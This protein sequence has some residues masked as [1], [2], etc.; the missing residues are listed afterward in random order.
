MKP[1]LCVVFATVVLVV[2]AP[3]KGCELDPFLFQLHGE[4]V[5]QAKERSDSIRSDF[6]IVG[7]FERETTDWEKA[8]S[9]Y[10]GRVISADGGSYAPGHRVLPSARIQPLHALKG[11]APKSQQVLT[12]EAQSGMCSDV[13]DGQASW[14]K[15]G[16]L[17]VVFTGLPRDD[18]RPRGIDSFLA[19]EIRTVDLLDKLRELGK[20]LED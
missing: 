15:P 3:A 9:V 17:V 11:E 14:A 19:M 16:E 5:A 13:G 18:Y 10:L 4:T 20:N 8:S 7:H 6:K 12:D 2:S 1:E